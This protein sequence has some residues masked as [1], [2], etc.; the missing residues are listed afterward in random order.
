MAAD[1]GDAALLFRPVRLDVVRWIDPERCFSSHC[2]DDRLGHRG[3]EIRRG[4]F[5]SANPEP[6]GDSARGK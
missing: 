2:G 5:R 1:A 6:D 3:G 4:F